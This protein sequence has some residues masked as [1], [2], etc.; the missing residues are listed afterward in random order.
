M[1]M[2]EG[3]AS[4]QRI[5][6]ETVRKTKDLISH[7]SFWEALENSVAITMEDDTL[8][9]GMPPQAS[10]L[11][12][13][14]TVSDHQNAINRTL[15]EITGR[16]VKMRLIHGHTLGDWEHT[17]ERDRRVQEMHRTTYKKKDREAAES[18]SWEALY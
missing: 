12:S 6:G 4:P 16:P 8:V 7:R 5:W 11:A 17:K 2:D 18:Q 15:E 14:L 1:R 10:N 13:F 3:G 9:I